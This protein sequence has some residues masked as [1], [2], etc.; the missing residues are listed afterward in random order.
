M[1][2]ARSEKIIGTQSLAV[3]GLA[4][5]D[6]PQKTLPTMQAAIDGTLSYYPHLWNIENETQV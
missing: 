2:I 6:I 1:G 4:V 3:L 5:L